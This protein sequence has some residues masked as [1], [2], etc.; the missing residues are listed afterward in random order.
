MVM[1]SFTSRVRYLPRKK[2]PSPMNRRLGGRSEQFG[3]EKNLAPSKEFTP[4][5]VSDTA[6]VQPC[7][8]L[9]DYYNVWDHFFFSAP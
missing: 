6:K 2:P 5:I 9:A 1:V 8:S 4:E 7:D 3:R